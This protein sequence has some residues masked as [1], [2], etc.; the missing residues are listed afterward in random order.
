MSG[1]QS[2]QLNGKATTCKVGD[3]SSNLTTDMGACETIY[4]CISYY[5]IEHGNQHLT[6]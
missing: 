3:V 2:V 1:R 5:I 4:N 6:Y